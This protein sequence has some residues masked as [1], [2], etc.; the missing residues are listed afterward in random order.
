MAV[1][2]DEVALA[3]L[4][5]AGGWDGLGRYTRQLDAVRR[6]LVEGPTCPDLRLLLQVNFANAHYTLWYLFE[7]RAMARDLVGGF[8]QTPP[9]SRRAPAAEAFAHYILGHTWRRLIAT[10]PE[11]A[12]A[13]ARAALDALRESHRL[14]TALAEEF[15]P[16]TR[17]RPA[18]RSV[19]A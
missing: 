2:P 7:A 15:G 14:Y 12:K 4:R 18:Q 5:E 13:S 9:K 17:R 6:G 8:G 11:H 1:S 16:G 3:A 10:Q 19:L